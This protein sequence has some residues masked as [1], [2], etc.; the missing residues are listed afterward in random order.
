MDQLQQAV[1]QVLS[2]LCVDMGCSA[3]NLEAVANE[4][5]RALL[6][7]ARVKDISEELRLA[8]ENQER[9]L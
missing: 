1:R 2:E 3:R 9:K 4:A 5:H 7:W 8:V 6:E